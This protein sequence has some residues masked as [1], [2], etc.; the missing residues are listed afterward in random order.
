MPNGAVQLPANRIGLHQ[1]IGMQATEHRHVRID[2]SNPC[3]ENAADKG[4]HEENRAPESRISQVKTET[5]TA[6]LP[7][8]S[9]QVRHQLGDAA[10]EQA[11]HQSSVVQPIDAHANKH[12]YQ[13]TELP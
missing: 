6:H 1:P 8:H 2:I 4:Q 11:E 13:D 7:Q 12:G 5:K 9:H 3:K 10:N